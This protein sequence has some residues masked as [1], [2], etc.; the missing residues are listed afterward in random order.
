MGAMRLAV[1]RMFVRGGVPDLRRLPPLP[2][3]LVAVCLTL[4]LA[5][6]ATLARAEVRTGTIGNGC[7]YTLDDSGK[8]TIRPTDGVSGEMASIYGALPGDGDRLN[9]VRSVVVERGVSAPEDS[10]HLFEGLHEAE[11]LDLS[12]LDTSRVTGMWRM[13]AG[14]SSLASLD[15]S[16]WDTSQVASMHDM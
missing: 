3:A 9:G 2:A 14:C 11:T 4:A 8:L 7:S 10:S 1:K 15:L 6:G 12:G 16:G 13:F 5:L